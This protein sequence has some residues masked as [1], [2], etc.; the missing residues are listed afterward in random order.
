MPCAA[1]VQP[2][3]INTGARN[4]A[5]M[6]PP[7][8]VVKTSSQWSKNHRQRRTRFLAPGFSLT[9][10]EMLL[11]SAV[12]LSTCGD[13]C[14][15]RLRLQGW[16]AYNRCLLSRA[17]MPHQENTPGDNT[18]RQRDQLR[19]RQQSNAVAV[20]PDVIQQKSPNRIQNQ[21][22]QYQIPGTQAIWIAPF[23]PQ[24]QPERGQVPQRLV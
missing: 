20:Q 8:S 6:N 15:M 3:R 12:L 23:D 21:V 7:K 22:N 13:L 9:L 17:S 19:G 18:R 24:Q 10:T 16:L 1:P 14:S 4:G 2:T 5:T 11:C